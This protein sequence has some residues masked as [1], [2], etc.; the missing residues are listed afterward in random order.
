MQMLWNECIFNFY[1]FAGLVSGL[2]FSEN[3]IHIYSEY[4]RKMQQFS[5]ENCINVTYVLFPM[6]SKKKT[7]QLL[8]FHHILL[9]INAHHKFSRNIIITSHFTELTFCKVVL[10]IRLLV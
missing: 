4:S 6:C 2:V 5:V 7:D 9:T 3:T 1:A 10:G 8:T